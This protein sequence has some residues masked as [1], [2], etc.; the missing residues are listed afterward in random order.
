MKALLLTGALLAT[1]TAWAQDRSLQGNAVN[2]QVTSDTSGPLPIFSRYNKNYVPGNAGE[3]YALCIQNTTRRRVLAVVSIDGVNVVSGQDAS[4]YQQGYVI[5]PGQTTRIDG[6]RKSNEQVSRFYF[7]Y[8]TDSY[9]S[10]TNRPANLGVIGV[11]VFD[12]K[13]PPPPPQYSPQSSGMAEDAAV[14]NRVATPAAAPSPSLGTGHGE[15]QYSYVNQVPFERAPTP[16]E[17]I[18]I[19]YDTWEV[20]Q[21]K[22]IVP[23]S[24][25]MNNRD[26][27]PANSYVPDPPGR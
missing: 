20:L 11:A 25:R 21:D 23:R 18:S 5:N 12:E 4:L 1:S 26:P 9:A 19:D 2:I 13:S 10:R 7:S 16:R 24:S 15:R 6:W 27:F 3:R 17:V 14:Q 8:P 22:G